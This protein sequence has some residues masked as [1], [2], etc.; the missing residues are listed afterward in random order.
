MS[1]PTSAEAV[2]YEVANGVATIL[3][4]RPETRNALS[5][6]VREGLRTAFQRFQED[7]EARVAIMTGAGD[8]AF[9]AGGDVKEIMGSG[10]G[11]VPHDYVPL[12]GRNLPVDKPWIAAVNGY[13]VGG[14]VLYTQLADL[15]IAGDT[16]RF[17]MP[18]ANLGRGA[19]WSVGMLRQMSRKVWFEMALTGVT[20]D[21]ERACQIGLVNRVVPADQL[22]VETRELAERVAAAAPLTVQATLR[23]TRYAR[24]LGE[25]EAWDR[26]DEEFADVYRSADALEGPRAWV[27]DREPQW[28][29]E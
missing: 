26:A 17:I 24:D 1:Q 15:A 4:D 13:A 10:L 25:S 3:I 18:E 2:R 19:P 16:A 23:M 20:I 28:R 27:E 29:G 8:R 7:T 12:P 11:E 9:C 5:A 22:L 6:E 14:G 21:A